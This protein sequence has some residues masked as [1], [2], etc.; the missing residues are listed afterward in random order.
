VQSAD[1]TLVGYGQSIT[2]AQGNVWT[3]TADGLVAVNG[4]PDLTTTNVTHLAYANGAVWQENTSDLWW[5]KSSPDA[6][7]D[8]PYGTSNVP[9]SV[10]CSLNNTLLTATGGNAR[11]A[12]TDAG[13]NT[14]TIVNG[15]V[16]VNGAV[17]ETTANVTH[18][19]YVNGVVWQEN[20]S[21]L[22]WSKTSPAASWDPPYG[23]SAVPGTIY[24]SQDDS[25]LGAPTAGSLSA[26]TD[27]SGNNWAIADG[28]VV[29]NGVAD[30]TTANVIQLAYVGGQIWQENSQG[31]WWYKTTPADGW[32]GGYGIASSPI[33]GAYYVANEPFDQA[34]IYVGKVTVQEPTTPPNALAAVVTT[35][36]EAD[37]TA[38]GISASGAN[39]VINGDS[40]LTNGATLTLLGAYRAPGQDYSATENNGAMTLDAST[41]HIGALSGTGSISANGSSLDIQSS[42]AGE[43]VNLQSSHLTIGGQ[44]GVG[45]GAGPAGGM[46]FL[47]P[48]TMDDSP[49]SSITLA[50]T[51]ATS[52]VLDETGGSLHEVF[53]Y[54]GSTEVA[55]LRLSGPSQLYAEQLTATPVPFSGSTPYVELGTPDEQCPASEGQ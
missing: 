30:L 54:N 32:N 11:S 9:V 38:I 49:A 53:L 42:T 12:I 29:V 27:Q 4:V 21:D 19:A 41:A 1:N 31:L 16:A 28:Q 20:T 22:W 48:I 8:P 13:G 14:W 52:M 39:I 25:V 35:G 55:D 45:A 44:D 17:D 46:S 10:S 6:S 34:T 47:A 37:G 15:R 2:D 24:A 23:T 51:Q 7:W 3:I 5:S 26:V 50:N 43:A 40:S 36:F 33:G 18:L